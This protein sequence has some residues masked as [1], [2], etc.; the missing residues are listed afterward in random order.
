MDRPSPYLEAQVR[1]IRAKDQAIFSDLSKLEHD[2]M[3]VQSNMAARS[4]RHHHHGAAID[5]IKTH[6]R[7]DSMKKAHQEEYVRLKDSHFAEKLALEEENHKLKKRLHLCQVELDTVSQSY[8]ELQTYSRRGGASA[9]DIGVLE[10]VMQAKDVQVAKMASQLRDAERQVVELR[11]SL[12]EAIAAI[13]RQH[14]ENASL[15]RKLDLFSKAL[16]ADELSRKELLS[17][18]DAVKSSRIHLEREVWRISNTAGA[19]L[20]ADFPTALR[21]IERAVQNSPFF[22][23]GSAAAGPKSPHHGLG[24]PEPAL[25]DHSTLHDP[26]TSTVTAAGDH[27]GGASSFFSSMH[28]QHAH[29]T[30]DGADELHRKVARLQKE[31]DAKTAALAAAQQRAN[32]LEMQ[33]VTLEAREANSPPRGEA[34]SSAA[35]QLRDLDLRQATQRAADLEKLVEALSQELQDLR[36]AQPPP[37]SEPDPA[38]AALRTEL[39]KERVMLQTAEATIGNLQRAAEAAGS[40]FEQQLQAERGRADELEQKLAAPPADARVLVLQDQVEKLRRDLVEQAQQAQHAQQPAPPAPSAGDTAVLEARLAGAQQGLAAANAALDAE[41]RAVDAGKA[42]IARLEQQLSDAAAAQDAQQRGIEAAHRDALAAQEEEFRELQTLLGTYKTAAESLDGLRA[43]VAT[44]EAAQQSSRETETLL[45]DQVAALQSE[46]DEATQALRAERRKAAELQDALNDALD[47]ARAVEAL[48]AEVK[49]KTAQLDA[50]R[51]EEDAAAPLRRR[52][53]DLENDLADKALETQALT[54]QVASLHA[55]SNQGAGTDAQIAAL[56]KEM[57][58]VKDLLAQKTALLQEA[59]Q[60]VA[61]G[62]ANVDVRKDLDEIRELRALEVEAHEAAL[63]KKDAEYKAQKELQQSLKESFDGQVAMANELRRS[64]DVAK[65]AAAAA[66][67]DLQDERAKHLALR[68]AS[69]SSPHSPTGSGS[70]GLSSSDG[71][72]MAALMEQ[73]QELAA[74]TRELAAQHKQRLAQLH[75]ALNAT[76][77][78]PPSPTAATPSSAELTGKLREAE[79]QIEEAKAQHTTRIKDLK[80]QLMEANKDRTSLKRDLM[81]AKRVIEAKGR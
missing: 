65:N 81:D 49:E 2:V 38:A 71:E 28:G 59:E 19:P 27:A 43:T 6:Q 72:A 36:M 20:D 75:A 4:H 55:E 60:K 40:A 51:G 22:A 53:A 35:A 32:S 34:A 66:E 11:R 76:P 57:E 68:R 5:D 61:A 54:D 24:S 78:P 58:T 48:Q 17:E 56:E 50:L 64:L 33:V 46:S 15:A 73:H 67:K 63:A 41:R 18:V 69:S 9:R 77:S 26:S 29:G 16:P 12:E 10:E 74:F 7:I 37:G 23:R 42:A 70:P 39:E 3:T 47:A 21:F 13:R 62:S 14:K 25:R 30:Q 44:L 45:N 80:A 1:G 52:V 8:A 79:K 31:I